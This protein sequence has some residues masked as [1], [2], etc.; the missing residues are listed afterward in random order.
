MVASVE[1]SE[2][3]VVSSGD[4]TSRWLIVGAN[5]MLGHDLMEVVAQSG[6]HVVGMDLPDMDITSAESVGRALDA[7]VPDVVV[8]AAA[9][10]AVDAAE[11]NEAIALRVNG[12]GPSVLAR[13]SSGMLAEIRFSE[14]QAAGPS[15]M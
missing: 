7:T 3:S 15:R 1:G 13:R 5:G 12:D 8:N 4:A 6:H 2:A 10:T 11:E 14:T 9:Y